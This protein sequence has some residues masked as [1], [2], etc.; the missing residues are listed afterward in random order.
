[1]GYKEIFAKIN[2]GTVGGILI[3]HGPEEYV[4]DRT[5]EALKARLVQPGMEDLNYQYLEGERANAGDI[6]RAAETLPFMSE[7]RLVVVRDYPMLASSSRGSGLDT[8]QE[9][10][11]LELLTRR[12]PEATCL[13]FLQRAA[14]DTTK[15][16]W[17]QLIKVADAVEFSRLTDDELLSQIA[18]MCK[19]NDC[20]VSREDARFLI[21]YVGN[22]LEVLNQE[23]DKACAYA[24]AGNNLARAHIEAV[25]V[26]S[27]EFK[28]FTFID[29]LFAGQGR[30]AM[31]KLRPLTSDPEGMGSMISLIERQARL[32]AAAKAQGKGA[33]MR[34]LASNLGA[35]PFA[36]EGAARQAA[37]WT[38]SNLAEVINRCAQADMKIKQGVTSDSTAVEELAMNVLQLALKRS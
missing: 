7:K 36:V 11:E 4:K 18:K 19:R 12:F 37:K 6:R 29:N 25:C 9:A 23:V 33:D 38:G 16:A 34:S 30:D 13:V 10:N 8:R 24:G 20:A 35:P 26:Q 14:V 3:L 21:Q 15:A 17:K 32:M 22:D 1:M 5:L 2:A 31:L 28:V 27:Q